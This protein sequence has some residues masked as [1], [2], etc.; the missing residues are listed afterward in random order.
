MADAGSE[1]PKHVDGR[2]LRYR[3]R[4]E[5]LLQAATD[6]V[7]E[8][9]LAQLSLRRIADSAGVSH[10]ALLHHFGTREQLVAEIV[11]RVLD[12]AFTAPEVLADEQRAADGG[13]PLRALWRQATTG[14]GEAYVRLFLAITGD[15]LHDE[16]LAAAVRRSV[17]E[18]TGLMEA[19]LVRA[20]C[21]AREAGALA[22]TVLGTMRGLVLDRL[23]TGDAAR[24][25]AAFEGFV[26]GL[27][28]QGER[29]GR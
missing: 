5:E 7:L 8:R 24:V 14:R 27:E 12:R 23:V 18:R 2:R 22:T 21:P 26:R 3:H 4:R 20:G 17:R 6:H 13:G 25:D 1:G 15:A 10:A 11:E 19:G 29:W 16:V 9:G 28:R